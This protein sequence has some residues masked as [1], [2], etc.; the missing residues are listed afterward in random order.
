MDASVPLLLRHSA[1]MP[2]V[3]RAALRSVEQQNESDIAASSPLPQTPIKGRAPLGEIAGN[4]GAE[5]EATNTSNDK[6]APAKKGIGAG[7]K[8]NAAKKASK[9]MRKNDE[10]L[11]VEVLEDEKQSMHSSAAE[12]ACQDL[13]KDGSQGMFHETLA[14]NCAVADTLWE[15]IGTTQA[16]G[17]TSQS[18]TPVSAAANTASEQLS[19]KPMTPYFDS[20]MHKSADAVTPEAKEGKEDSFVAEIESRTP[21]KMTSNE[22]ID[23]PLNE[24]S[25][26]DDSFVEQIKTRTP[27][28]RVSRIED[29]VEALD[30][31]EEEIDKVGGL[32][33]AGA[34]SLRSLAKAKKQGESQPASYKQAGGSLRIKKG[35]GVQKKIGTG[36]P[37]N[38]IGPTTS[39]PSAGSTKT[40]VRPSTS[41][42]QHKK[43]DIATQASNF[44]HS[45]GQPTPQAILKNRIIS[46]YKAPFQPVKSTKPLTRAN[47]ELPGTAVARKLK[48]QREERLKHEE[49]EAPKPRIFKARP[50]HLSHAPEVKLTAA[51]KAR[52]SMAKGEP[53]NRTRPSDIA[54]SKPVARPAPIATASLNKRLSTLSVA[55]RS[56]QSTARGSTQPSTNGSTRLTRGPSLKASTPTRA[57]SALGANRPAPTAEESAHQKLKG[58]EVFGRTRVEIMEREKAKKENED[59]ARKARADAAERG[60]KAS[61]QWAEKQKARKLES[62]KVKDQEKVVVSL[63]C[64]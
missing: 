47:F 26:K 51:T 6:V 59:A 8:G 5:N 38:T 12:E 22:E 54:S 29:S 3:T 10:E 43:T 42:D 34:D 36:R 30:A 24:E 46:V 2:R 18:Q 62:R 56:V 9:Q 63:P 25:N 4:R 35:T 44:T 20:E 27:G 11:R 48:E 58:K 23:M 39:N 64:W 13:L 53:T 61:R 45:G 1:I 17:D 28:K 15:S 52:L 37:S 55:K 14:F 49:E 21:M 50:I 41:L 7:K 32:I 19:P 33:P 16:V 31:L 60:R 57:P 40:R